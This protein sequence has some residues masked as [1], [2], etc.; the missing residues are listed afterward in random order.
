MG[1][2]LECR[3]LEMDWREVQ[4]VR[5]GAGQR[6]GLSCWGSWGACLMVSLGEVSST[7]FAGS[8]VAIVSL[9]WSGVV[10]VADK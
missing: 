5:K 6:L 3:A 8:V 10:G 9:W 1:G 7:S 4:V 2:G